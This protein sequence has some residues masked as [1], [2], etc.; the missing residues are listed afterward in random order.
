MSLINAIEF[1]TAVGTKSVELHNADITQWEKNYDVL[2]VSAFSKSYVPTAESLIGHLK[3]SLKINLREQSENPELDF[4]KSMGIWLSKP[5]DNQNFKRIICVESGLLFDTERSIERI[6]VNL[7]SFISILEYQGIEIRTIVMPLL[8]TGNQ[9]LGEEDVIPF[10]MRYCKKALETNLKLKTIYIVE[11][12]ESKIA[13]LQSGLNTYLKDEKFDLN[14]VSEI[15]ADSHLIEELIKGLKLLQANDKLYK[16]DESVS[17]IIKRLEDNDF[18]FYE[19]GIMCRRFLELVACNIL[20][21]EVVTKKLDSLYKKINALTHKEIAPWIIA[22]FQVVRQVGN[23]AAHSNST[24]ETIPETIGKNDIQ[25][26]II[27]LS[28]IVNFLNK[29]LHKIK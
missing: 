4:R 14:L 19:F 18:K 15:N 3:E 10:M 12:S 17:I 8:G 2:V 29:S 20:K 1:E 16:N 25:A 13:G 22:Y 23:F 7:F 26:L 5:I 24:A 27:I 28:N 11:K 9:Y 6:F 21:E